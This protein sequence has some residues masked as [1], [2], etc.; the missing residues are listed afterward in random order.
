MGPQRLKPVP[1]S[2]WG[3]WMLVRE[4]SQGGRQAQVLLWIRAVVGAVTFINC[5]TLLFGLMLLGKQ[6]IGAENRLNHSAW[7]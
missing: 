7:P 2:S 6:F 3:G 4:G 5:F 1:W